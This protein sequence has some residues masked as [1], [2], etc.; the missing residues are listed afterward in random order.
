MPRQPP[1]DRE[2][3]AGR[4][5]T[6]QLPREVTR[7]FDVHISTIYR[8]QSRLQTIGS[9]ADHPRAGRPRVTTGQVCL[10]MRHH[11]RFPFNTAED[12]G[13]AIVG[14]HSRQLTGR[15]V[16]CRLAK[17]NLP[18]RRPARGPVLLGLHRQQQLQWAQRHI[19]WRHRE[20]RMVLFTDE[21]RFCL[22]PPDGSIRIW[23]AS[24]QR[25]AGA[26]ILEKD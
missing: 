19:H 13:R 18:C 6:G 14:T 23:R 5:A 15:T 9:N 16:R 20:W 12:T 22:D 24:G 17:R 25:F 7:A 21:S 8:L 1:Q 11:R 10:I 2:R 26:N 3:A 4:L